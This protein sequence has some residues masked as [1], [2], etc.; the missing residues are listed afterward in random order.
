MK[1]SPAS[2]ALMA[3]KGSLIQNKFNSVLERKPAVLVLSS[4]VG[5]L[6]GEEDSIH[7]EFSPGDIANFNFCPTANANKEGTYS[8]YK[9][10]FVN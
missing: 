8:V 5:C 4:I 1:Q 6:K 2:T 3:K 9:T 10:V 7:E